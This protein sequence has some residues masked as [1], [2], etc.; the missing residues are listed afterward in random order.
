MKERDAAQALSALGHE[1]RLKIY[2]LLVRAGPQGLNVGEI[3]RHLGVPASTLAHH[4]A[5][6]ARGGLVV[7]ARNGR[8]VVTSADYAAM[9]GLVAFLTEEC[10][11]GVAERGDEAA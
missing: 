1:A 6:L 8:E 5:A 4:I 2:R 9:D 3:G 11:V 10:C 7:Q